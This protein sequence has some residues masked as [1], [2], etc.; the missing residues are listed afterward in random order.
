MILVID[1]FDSFT[2]NLVQYIQTVDE[3]VVVKRNNEISTHEINE[4]CPDFILISPG[5]GNPD[6]A[7]VCLDVVKEFYNKIPILG[8]CLGHQIIAQ[9]FG[10]TVRKALKPMHGKVEKIEHDGRQ[11][12][13]DIPSRA[14]VTRYHSLI[15]D[16]ATL[17]DCL[18]VSAKTI[19][20]EI[21]ALRH[22]EFNVEGVQFHPEAILTEN[23]LQMIQNFFTKNRGYT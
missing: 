14:K 15:V 11:I 10:G 23:G 13:R 18:E 21:M 8:V 5:P 9:A 22:K 6:T 4:L 19:N 20:G 2:F 16:E 7:G 17:P 12:F 3:E 1:N